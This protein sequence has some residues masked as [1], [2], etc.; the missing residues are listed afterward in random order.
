MADAV[1]AH[2]ASVT[3]ATTDADGPSRLGVAIGEPI[4]VGDVEYRYFRRGWTRDWHFSLGL[5]RWLARTVARFDVVEVHGLFNYV[6]A[7]GCRLA[8]RSRVPYV[9]RPL[10]TLAPWSLGR[11]SWKKR[12]YYQLIERTHLAHAAAIHVTSEAE[13]AE[14][15]QLGFGAKAR[16]IPLGVS[17]EAAPPRADR[18]SREAVRLLF[19]SRLHPKKGL[20]LLFTALAMLHAEKRARVSL[21]VAGSGESQYVRRLEAQVARLGLQDAVRFVGPVHGDAK[22]S[23]FSNA[24]VF[25]LPSYNENFGIAAAEAFAAGLPAILSDEVAL[26]RDAR[27]RAAAL[28]VALDPTA[29]A[30]AI[31]KLAADAALRLEM[32]RNAWRFA[33]EVLSWEA[34]GIRLMALYEELAAARRAA[35]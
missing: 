2:G 28:V 31:V 14:V 9:L 4:L 10:G 30:D 3:I 29:I 7:A 19:L 8:W 11:G 1:A 16:V 13:A 6:T 32:G 22:T 27:S 33:A 35:S 18:D 5:T 23:A 15:T 25:V 12:P 24:D 21:T 34:C 26:A 20:E 17:V